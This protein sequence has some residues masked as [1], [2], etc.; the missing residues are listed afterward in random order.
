[1]LVLYCL[2]IWLTGLYVGDSSGSAMM[3][4]A[5]TLAA[6]SAIATMNMGK[7]LANLGSGKGA[8]LLSQ[9]MGQDIAGDIAKGITSKK[10]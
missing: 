2:T 3:N 4:M 8:N 6:T 1:M 7:I 5:V 10:D 9:S